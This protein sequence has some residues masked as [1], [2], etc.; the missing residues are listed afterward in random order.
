VTDKR[1]PGNPTRSYRTRA[2]LHIVGEVEE[3]AV[4]DPSVLQT[5]LESLAR[6]RADG[7][8]VIEVQM[9]WRTA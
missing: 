4:H 7:R 9:A 5:M 3:L 2:P 6:L 1:L 8:D